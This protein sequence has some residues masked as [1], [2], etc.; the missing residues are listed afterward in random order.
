[1]ALTEKAREMLKEIEKGS[2]EEV[3]DPLLAIFLSKDLDNDDR[4]LLIVYMFH[5]TVMRYQWLLK[6]TF[7]AVLSVLAYL[8]GFHKL[9]WELLS[10]LM[11]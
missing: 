7:F 10:S 5:K 4:F 1:M 6:W 8:M 3:K 11:F 2:G 9:A